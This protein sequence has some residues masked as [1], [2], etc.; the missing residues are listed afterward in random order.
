MLPLPPDIKS[1]LSPS[2]ERDCLNNC[3]RYDFF[4]GESTP[5]HWIDG[6]G[7]GGFEIACDIGG[8]ECDFVRVG[9]EFAFQFRPVCSW[10]EDFDEGL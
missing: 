3:R 4:S 5:C 10:E 8:E 2:P 7:V 1:L 9:F 6:F